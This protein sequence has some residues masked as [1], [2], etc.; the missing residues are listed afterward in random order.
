MN[1]KALFSILMVAVL[2]VPV[3]LGAETSILMTDNQK[4]VN[5]YDN[6]DT[7]TLD[8]TIYSSET[9]DDKTITVGLSS[10][11]GII[12]D[13][14]HTIIIPAGTTISTTES[15]TM[16]LEKELVAGGDYTIAVS[17]T[18]A[19]TYTASVDVEV[20]ESNPEELLPGM[21]NEIDVEDKDLTF[22]DVLEFEVEVEVDD[23]EIVEDAYVRVA[24]FNADGERVDSWVESEDDNIR[25]D[26]D[27]EETYTQDDFELSVEIP[28]DNE[29]DEG[30][31]YLCVEIYGD[32]DTYHNYLLATGCSEDFEVE[33]LEDHMTLEYVNIEQQGNILYTAINVENDGEENQGDV[34]AQVTING[35]DVKQSSNKVTVYEDDDAT[36]YVP[37]ILPAFTSGEYDIKVTVYNDDVSVSETIAYDL[38]GIVAAQTEAT[39]IIGVDTAAKTVSENGAVYAMTFTNNGASARTFSLET[40]GA[41]W[42]QTSA[43]PA[44]VVVGPGTSE[45]AS[46]FVAP[47][48]GEQGT[49]QFTVFIKEGAQ[50]VKSVSL[51][52]NVEGSND[53]TGS[54]VGDFDNLVNSGL[55]WI[56]AILV[57][58]L[59]VLFVVWSWNKDDEEE[60]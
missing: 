47:N 26:D 18:G 30:F 19:V 52:A 8:F 37:V 34:R 58:V 20:A 15:L 14:S 25:F 7:V 32:Y 4:T 27:D 12:S 36:I 57:V 56:A 54:A 48:A 42:G 53:V 41:E 28:S 10:A 6:D 2:M 46:I 55:K 35:L 51:T 38:T 5:L 60:L 49:R 33:R 3:A 17:T 21:I 40:A 44:T 50:I 11:E 29:V 31:Y 43:N 39:L 13:Q 16:A 1:M 45:I 9:T 59:I 22:N 24:L 23:D